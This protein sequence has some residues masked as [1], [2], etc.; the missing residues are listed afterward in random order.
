MESMAASC[1]RR[2]CVPLAG[3]PAGEFAFL[4]FRN[5]AR[6]PNRAVRVDGEIVGRAQ[7]FG[8]LFERRF[9][10]ADVAGDIVLVDLGGADMLPQFALLRQAF[11]VGPVPLKFLRPPYGAPLAPGHNAEKIALAHNLNQAGPVF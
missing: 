1:W 4:D 7:P 11:P 10:V 9:G 5:G 8:G 6:R 3:G 2:S